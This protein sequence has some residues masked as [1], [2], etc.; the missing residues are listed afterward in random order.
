MIKEHQILQQLQSMKTAAK[1]R[2]RKKGIAAPV[3]TKRGLKIDDYEIV[4]EKAGYAIY[5]KYQDKL[6]KNLYYLQTAVLIANAMATRKTVKDQWIL[7]DTAAGTSDFDMKLFDHRYTASVKKQDMFGVQHY[8][9]RLT[10]SKIKHKSYMNSLNNAYFMLLNTLK[11]I[12]K[13]NKYS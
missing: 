5:D 10:E 13:T 12:E 3:K 11:S 2:L 4:L 1:D 8:L 6:Y 7:D 9:T